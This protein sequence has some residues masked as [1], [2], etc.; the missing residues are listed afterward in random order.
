MSI[1]ADEALQRARGHLRQAA[2]EGLEAGR[3][4]LQAATQ[5]GA[6]PSH[7]SGDSWLGEMQR[8]LDDLITGLRENGSFSLPSSLVAPLSAALETE[9]ARW[10]RRSQTDADARLVLRAF[11]GL[12][13][14]LW[15]V[16]M[17]P[18]P[19]STPEK[20]RPDLDRHPPP[21]PRRN[22]VERFDI[23]D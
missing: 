11:L 15:E 6:R 18:E 4:L 21:P 2:L 13:E 17:R 10:E 22:R 20:A 16:G 14:L 7:E 9:I 12:R 3:A 19:P 1:E 8:S 5:A 23:G